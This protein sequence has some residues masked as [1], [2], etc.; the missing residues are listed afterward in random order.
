[1]FDDPRDERRYEKF[2]RDTGRLVGRLPTRAT[3]EGLVHRLNQA[4]HAFPPP[5]VWLAVGL[6]A[7]VLR[8]PQRALVALSP[9]FAALVVI[10]M[11]SLVA[12]SVAEYVAPVSPAFVLLAAAGLV[13]EQPRGRLRGWA[14][15]RL[16]DVRL[17]KCCE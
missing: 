5:I 11:T 15:G 4:S 17:D 9:A 2:G 1:V 13:G 10:V 8:R 14:R 6:V 16:P 3:K 12:L 7:V